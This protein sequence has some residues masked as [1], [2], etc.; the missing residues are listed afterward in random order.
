MERIISYDWK[1]YIGEIDVCSEDKQYTVKAGYVNECELYIRIFDS[2]NSFIMG[3]WISCIEYRDWY[4]N[5]DSRIS[6]NTVD[7][8]I[9]AARL[10]EEL[11]I[12]A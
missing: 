2:A 9:R 1:F 10:L 3:D 7:K 11:K 6:K 4:D 8:C 12:F 5:E